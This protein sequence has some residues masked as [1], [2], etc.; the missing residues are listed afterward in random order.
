MKRSTKLQLSSTH[1]EAMRDTIVNSKD[2]SGEE[3]KQWRKGRKRWG[4]PP[5]IEIVFVGS[6]PENNLE[7]KKMG[8]GT[9]CLSVSTFR[10]LSE[11]WVAPD[12]NRR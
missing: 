3:R 12:L 5:K 7:R 9:Y 6:I 2:L 1:K 11:A 4:K 10:S 8:T